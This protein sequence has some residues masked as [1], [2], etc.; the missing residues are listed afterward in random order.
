MFRTNLP[1]TGA[2]P[3]PQRLRRPVLTGINRVVAARVATAETRTPAMASTDVA[4]A[5][6]DPVVMMSSTRTTA[7]PARCAAARRVTTRDRT[8][9]APAAARALEAASRWLESDLGR[10]TSAGASAADSPLARIR[11]TACRAIRAIWSP[12]RARTAAVV[13]GMATTATGR[14]GWP[15]RRRLWSRPGPRPA[16]LPTDGRLVPYN[17]APGPATGRRM[18]QAPRIRAVPAVPESAVPPPDAMHPGPA[19]RPRRSGRMRSR[20]S[21]RRRSGTRDRPE[22]PRTCHHPVGE[23]R[24][25]NRRRT[26]PVACPS[27]HCC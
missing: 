6:V 7:A 23:E 8:R 24:R 18:D 17:P 13:D 14:P 4:A 20:R 15:H 9:K 25:S 3:A 1:L 19:R 22:H 26:A 10:A 21:R 11:S 16:T 27:P 12:C 2:R 5:R